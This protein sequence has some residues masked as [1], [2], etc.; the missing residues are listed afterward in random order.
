MD[1]ALQ[2][3]QQGRNLPQKELVNLLLDEA[4]RLTASTIGYF[5]IADESRNL[6]TMVGWSKSAMALCSSREIPIEYPINATGLW[7]DCIRERRPVITNDYERCARP[8]KK[9]YPEGHVPVTRH[10]NVP[11]MS[12]NAIKGILGVGNKRDEYTEA[13]A[14]LLQAFAGA[15]WTV[16]A[17]SGKDAA[18]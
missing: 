4:I 1:L 3:L 9:G 10:M 8:T 14:A 17:Q 18:T 6:L 5:A 11:V 16:F 12:G 15:A 7:G 13:D 2:R